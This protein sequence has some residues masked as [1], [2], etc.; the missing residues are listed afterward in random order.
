M[1]LLGLAPDIQL[2]ITDD[3]LEPALRLGSFGGNKFLEIDS[4]GTFKL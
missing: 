2:D 1:R 3:A 4:Y